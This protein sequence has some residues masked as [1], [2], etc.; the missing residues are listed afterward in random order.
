MNDFFQ[1]QAIVAKLFKLSLSNTN[2]GKILLPFFYIKYL[3]LMYDE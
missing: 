3:N 1:I 2:H